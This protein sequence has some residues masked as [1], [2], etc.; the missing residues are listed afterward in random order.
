ME[1]KYINDPELIVSENFVSLAVCCSRVS[2][3]IC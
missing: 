2:L 3:Q 1:F